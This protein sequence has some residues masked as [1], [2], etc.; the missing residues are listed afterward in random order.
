M[1]LKDPN[2]VAAELP[3]AEPPN[4]DTEP[5]AE[6]KGATPARRRRTA[7]VTP[8]KP[9]WNTTAANTVAYRIPP[10]QW[11]Q[12]FTLEMWSAI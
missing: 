1:A 12:L 3:K 6:S 10:P 7:R 4:T 11:I 8:D 5:E 9:E 2:E